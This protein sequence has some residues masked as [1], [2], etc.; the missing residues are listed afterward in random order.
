MQSDNFGCACRR[1]RRIR[2]S[3]DELLIKVAKFGGTSMATADAVRRAVKI[4]ERS[5]EIKAVAVSAGGKETNEKKI[6]DE[7]IAAYPKLCE[8]KSEEAA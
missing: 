1:T 2:F 8:G 4:S 3:G 7:L 6:T 5:G